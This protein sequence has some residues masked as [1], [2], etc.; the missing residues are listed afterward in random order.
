[1]LKISNVTVDYGPKRALDNVSLDIPLGGY[2]LGIVGESGS[3]K[4]T[5]GNTMMRLIKSP[6]KIVSGKVEFNGSDVL[7]M[8]SKELR[9]YRWKQISMVFQ[10]A[11]NALNPVK[12]VSDH[13]SEVLREHSDVKMSEARSVAEDLLVKVGIPANRIRSFPHEFSGGMRQR[14]VIAMALALSPRLLIA[15]EPT[16]ALD[17]VVQDQILAL[18]QEQVSRQNLS[19]IFI[20]HEISL[21]AGLVDNVAVMYEGELIELGQLNSVLSDP[22]HPYS[23]MLLESLLSLDSTRD[24]LFKIGNTVESADFSSSL[25]IGCKYAARCNYRF[26]RCLSER[27][28]LREIEKGRWVSCHK[29]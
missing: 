26:E 19:L 28:L 21:L 11:M 3:G 12:T 1:L 10:S 9:N 20:T 17:I 2:T 8:S 25:R 18:I 15:D 5:M 6:G 7:A 29:Y 24:A 22:L 27:P 14:T 23:E 4:T 16:S 13:I